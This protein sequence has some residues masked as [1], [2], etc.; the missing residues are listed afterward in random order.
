M[1]FA[2]NILMFFN[3]IAIAKYV[4]IFWMKN[5]GSLQDDF[6]TVFILAWTVLFNGV[7]N[8]TR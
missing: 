8:F 3:A 5:P 7:F 1:M 4:F 2:T 6:W